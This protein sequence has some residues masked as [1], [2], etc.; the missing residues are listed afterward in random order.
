MVAGRK[1][2]GFLGL[3]AGLLHVVLGAGCG[4]N[5]AGDSA[6]LAE[7]SQELSEPA[8]VVSP[9]DSPATVA[10]D[11]AKSNL[12]EGD[13]AEQVA[14][15][16]EQ[17][18]R[19]AHR[20]DETGEV[21]L[22]RPGMRWFARRGAVAIV[23]RGVELDTADNVIGA[24]NGDLW[25]MAFWL[26][27]V[28]AGGQAAQFGA[29]VSTANADN[30]IVV[31][32]GSGV[33]EIHENLPEGIE[34]RFIVSTGAPGEVRLL[35]R[36][37]GFRVQARLDDAGGVIFSRG[38]VDVVQ[39]SRPR[40]FTAEGEELACEFVLGRRVLDI[41]IHG[42]SEYPV[43]VDPVWT[44]IGDPQVGATFADAISSAGDING[45]GLMD[46]IVGASTYDTTYT[47]VG[48]AYLFLG[49]ATQGLAS[50]PV[51]TSIG[52]NQANA[53]FGR[54]VASAGDMDGDGNPEV[55]IASPLEN[56]IVFPTMYTD[57]SVIG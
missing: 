26:D 54:A 36:F 56:Y 13:W 49:T 47:A 21:V 25:G 38:E 17:D 44:S 30:M 7:K 50:T 12:R 8:K 42:V 4:P 33:E 18:S 27:G 51:W 43:L 11:Q 20:R 19:R 57:T 40:A 35:G 2:V 1:S 31:E 28:E 15:Y 55:M 16:I 48:K 53:A 29:P 37:L 52:P 6:A 34:Q 22:N 3:V 32:H 41:V 5:G 39:V 46:V 23:S 24:A 45:D 14:R 9:T 10:E